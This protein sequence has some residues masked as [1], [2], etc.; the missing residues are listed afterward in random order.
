MVLFF[1][2]FDSI[3][4]INIQHKT[5]GLIV[6]PAY[7]AIISINFEHDIAITKEA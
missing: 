5:V 1:R 7:K 3:F 4:M 6:N 2:L